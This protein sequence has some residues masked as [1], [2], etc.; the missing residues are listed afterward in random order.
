LRL[1]VP[2]DRL[3]G[4][5]L[6]H[7][8]AA[9]WSHVVKVHQWWLWGW[10]Y[11][12]TCEQTSCNHFQHGDGEFVPC[13]GGQVDSPSGP[14]DAASAVDHR[15]TRVCHSPASPTAGYA[16][17]VPFVTSMCTQGIRIDIPNSGNH[18]H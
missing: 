6:W 5:P 3:R 15:L 4:R 11:L 16:F 8:V 9:V 18:S 12:T 14:W 10:A 7:P 1:K 2:R 17:G 13:T